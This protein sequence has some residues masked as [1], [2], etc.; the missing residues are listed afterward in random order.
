MLVWITMALMTGAAALAVLWPLARPQR[1]GDNAP[2]GPDAAFYRAQ[3]AEIER[4]ASRGLIAPD[5]AEVARTEAGRRVLAAI[6]REGAAASDSTSQLRIRVAAAGALLIL[7]AVSLGVYMSV[8]RPDLPAQPL[9]SR[10]VARGGGVSMDEA[11]A[12]I[13]KHLAANPEDGRA[14][15]LVAPVYMS[16]GRYADAAKAY[17]AALR[18]L[19]P[20]GERLENLAEAYVATAD[21]VVTAE[22]RELFERSLMVEPGRPK[23]RFYRGLAAEQDGDRQAAIAL[24]SGLIDDAPP[25]SPIAANLAQRITK[26]GGTPPKPQPEATTG[27]GSA[28]G[29][30]VAALPEQERMAAIRGMVETLDARL[31]ADGRDVDGW[32]RLVRSYVV[33]GEADKARSAL[34]RGRTALSGDAAGRDRLEALAREFALGGS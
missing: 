17:A 3:L 28:A 6:R 31:A 12:K 34:S 2:E 13:E 15:E 18:L 1:A 11:V 9:A 5:E 7:P 22:A 20:S 14:Q 32:L 10:D 27:P 21:G 19:G 24:Y 29:A 33:L 23:A 16:S 4:D 30:A 26:L 8:G 25:G